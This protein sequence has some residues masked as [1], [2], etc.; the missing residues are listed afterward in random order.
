[1]YKGKSDTRDLRQDDDDY[2]GNVTSET[3]GVHLA[4]SKEPNHGNDHNRTAS[5]KHQP[6]YYLE[7]RKGKRR[8]I[9]SLVPLGDKL[10]TSILCLFKRQARHMEQKLW[11]NLA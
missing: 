10:G 6:R 3:V 5:P 7:K 1:M 4:H 11:K 9:M 8:N 2:D